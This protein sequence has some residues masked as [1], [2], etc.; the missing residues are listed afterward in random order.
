MRRNLIIAS[1]LFYDNFQNRPV[2]DTKFLHEF[3]NKMLWL[4]YVAI[5]AQNF[6][7]TSLIYSFGRTEDIPSGY[8]IKYSFGKEFGEFENRNYNALELAAGSYLFNSGYFHLSTVLG[9]YI[10]DEKEFQQGVIK[11]QGDY[12]TK[13]YISGRYKFRHFA[14][15]NFTRGINRFPTERL[16]LN[17]RDGITGINKSEINGK[18]KIVLN[19]QTVSFT[20]YLLYGFRF[21]FFGFTDL[22]FLGRGNISITEFKPYSAFGFGVRIRNERLVFPTFQLRFALYPNITDLDFGDYVHFQGE[23]KLNPRRF[24]TEAPAPVIFR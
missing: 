14:S 4:N 17:E 1:G 15:I 11:V 16:N 3:H 9:G 13:L 10:T 12:F 21:A 18:Q 22:G 5:T 8:I 23:E 20:P 2:V 7:R 19:L 24:Y 6:Y